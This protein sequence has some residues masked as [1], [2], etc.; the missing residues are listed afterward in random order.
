M[1][2]LDNIL[3]WLYKKLYQYHRE[4]AKTLARKREFL[5]IGHDSIRA[6]LLQRHDWIGARQE[7]IRWSAVWDRSFYKEC[8]A[9]DCAAK[10][11]TKIA[12]KIVKKFATF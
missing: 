9:N 6:A 8:R 1:K 7:S 11:A 10:Y 12:D 3:L 5:E 4:K 2:V